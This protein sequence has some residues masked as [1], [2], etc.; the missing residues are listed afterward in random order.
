MDPKVIK[1]LWKSEK[2]KVPRTSFEFWRQ[3]VE[4]Q[5]S[6]NHILERR[7]KGLMSFYSAEAVP[8]SADFLSIFGAKIHEKTTKNWEKKRSGIWLHLGIDF[9]AFFVEFGLP[10][11]VSLTEYS[12]EIRPWGGC[13]VLGF[14]LASFWYRFGSIFCKFWSHFGSPRHI[15]WQFWVA[16]RSYMKARR[17]ARE[18]LNNL[19]FGL[20]FLGSFWWLLLCSVA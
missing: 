4:I 19:L 14:V 13:R 5:R 7:Y 20:P 3:I 18:R 10:R 2:K 8:K 15:F 11:G 16:F 9:F 6:P 1:N 17:P 12:G